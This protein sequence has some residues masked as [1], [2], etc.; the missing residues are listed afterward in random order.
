MPSFYRS[1][2]LRHAPPSFLSKNTSYRQTQCNCLHFKRSRVVACLLL[3][4]VALSHPPALSRAQQALAVDRRSIDTYAITNARIFSLAGNSIIER[5]TVVIR[6]GLIENVGGQQVRVPADARV[7][8][9]AGLTVYPGLIDAYTALG[10][11]AAG[12][13]NVAAAPRG[14]A[15]PAVVPVATATPPPNATPSPAGL[16]PEVFAADLLQPNSAPIEAARNAGITAALTAP[17]DGIFA[18]QS[19]LIN[20]AG[21]APEDMILRSP[22]AMHAGFTPPR[23]SGYPSSLMGV[24]AALRQA[25]LDAQHYRDANAAYERGARGLRRLAPDRSLAALGPVIARQMPVVMY[26]D[27]EREIA[28]AL[29]LAQE[30]NVRVIIAGGLESWKI[31]D[32]LRQMSVP[33]LLSLNFPKR[34][35]AQLPEAD[36]DSLRVLRERAAAPKTAA[37]LAA[38]GVRFAFHSGTMTNMADF[39]PNVAKVVANGLAPDEALRALTLRPAE[40]FN[41]ADRLGTIEPGKIANLVVSRGDLFDRNSRL[42]HV[43]I[44]GRP[45]DLKPAPAAPAP[46]AAPNTTGTWT[47]KIQAEAGEQSATLTLRQEGERLT[48]ALQGDLG[49]AQIANGSVSAAGAV[50]FSAPI[51]IGGLTSEATF[52]GTLAGNEMR[53]TVQI[54]GRQPTTFTGV[55]GG[56]AEPPRQLEFNGGLRR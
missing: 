56:V 53:G 6:N 45:I 29:D 5:G 47:L 40:I 16:L 3:V 4:A 1:R 42:T 44:D 54:V 32:R 46:G 41:V 35:T 55:R 19:A 39:A 51:Q 7:I 12:G 18:G 22:V 25:L 30:F 17:R 50:R 2:I 33:V 28:R 26:A 38:A 10:M 52:A 21:A 23:A 14:A 8:D 9:G 13:G 11:P 37:R 15:T 48:G 24:F 27:S 31:A 36:P 34:A 20:L 43:F 49:A